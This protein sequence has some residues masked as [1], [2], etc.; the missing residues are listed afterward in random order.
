VDTRI[1]ESAGQQT[2]KA[3][4]VSSTQKRHIRVAPTISVDPVSQGHKGRASRT[5]HHNKAVHVVI[6]VLKNFRLYDLQ[7]GLENS[8]AR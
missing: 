6:L 1:R 3:P 4:V 5:K 7:P 2:P 8:S